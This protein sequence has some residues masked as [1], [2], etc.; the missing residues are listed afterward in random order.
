MKVVSKGDVLVCD[1]C[2]QDQDAV[3]EFV[4]TPSWVAPGAAVHMWICR[5]C[6]ENSLA[7]IDNRQ[8]KKKEDP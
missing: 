2:R 5:G 8:K 3:V 1:I 7:V 6:L 4:I